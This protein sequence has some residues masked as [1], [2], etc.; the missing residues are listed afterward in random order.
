MGQNGVFQQ[1][2]FGF[3]CLT[4][5]FNSYYEFDTPSVGPGSTIS[6]QGVTNVPAVTINGSP[7]TLSGGNPYTF[8]LVS[9]VNRVRF[10]YDESLFRLSDVS[11]TFNPALV[12]AGNCNQLLGL[13]SYAGNQASIGRQ[14][15]AP[16]QETSGTIVTDES[17]Y[18]RG[19]TYSNFSAT[20]PTETGPTSWLPSGITWSASNHA[21]DLTANSVWENEFSVMGMGAWVRL[22]TSSGVYSVWD[23]G[24]ST[25]GM[26]LFFRAGA[27]VFGAAV[28]I[29]GSNT[30]VQSGVQ[31]NPSVWQFISATFDNGTLTLF[32]DGVQVDQATGLSATVPN[33]ANAS[34]IGANSGNMAVSPGTPQSFDGGLAGAIALSVDQDWSEFYNGPE[35]LNTVAPTLSFGP[36]TW[37]GT[38]GTWDS[39][40]NG[41]I[42]YTWQLRRSSDNGVEQS[43]TGTPSGSNPAAGDYY[44]WV[45]AS[46]DGGYDEAEDSVSSVQT[47]S[48]SS[49]PTFQPAWA[50]ASRGQLIG[51]GVS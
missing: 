32:I 12:T 45:R 35:P 46:N 31:S 1:S 22:D 49:G 24:G 7:A 40:L 38:L 3:E 39:Q 42:T 43:G 48:G 34:A 26:A 14:F 30:E 11:A 36:S 25:N 15:Y 6:F 37:A 27:G 16:M 8:S 23:V 50:L 21:I 47:S 5:D 51:G 13:G 41:T 19:A 33:H 44:L 28:G 4:G 10:A 29:N 18:S 17:G 9:G 2:A 20:L